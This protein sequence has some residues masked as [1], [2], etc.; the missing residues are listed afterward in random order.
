MITYFKM[1]WKVFVILFNSH[2]IYSHTQ[3]D[4]IVQYYFKY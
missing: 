4:E 1:W 3:K 2:M